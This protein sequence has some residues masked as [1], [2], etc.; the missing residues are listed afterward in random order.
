MDEKP[1]LS[2]KLYSK[3]IELGEPKVLK[4]L[5]Q[6]ERKLASQRYNYRKRKAHLEELEATSEEGN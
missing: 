5:S 4:I 1:T 6:W 2:R 3:I